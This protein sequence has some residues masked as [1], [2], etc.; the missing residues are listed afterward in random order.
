MVFIAPAIKRRVAASSCQDES[1][2]GGSV[3][4]AVYAPGLN[5]TVATPTRAGSL[6][7]DAAEVDGEGLPV[8]GDPVVR[9]G[10]LV[11]GVDPVVGGS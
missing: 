4:H 8:G 9:V 1:L 10:R 6:A 11:R 7:L 2:T 5:A 3:C